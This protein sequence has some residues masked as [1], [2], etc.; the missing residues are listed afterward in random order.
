MPLEIAVIGAG[1]SGLVAAKELLAVGFNVTV[2][3][4]GSH[5]G[6]IWAYSEDVNTPS[7]MRHTVMNL[8]TAQV[9]HL[10]CMKIL[11]TNM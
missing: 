6:G 9:S 3:E 8:S 10:G 7:V 5:V 11:P 4:K 2:F 1:V